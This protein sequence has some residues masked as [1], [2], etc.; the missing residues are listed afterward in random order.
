MTALISVAI[1]LVAFLAVAYVR[2]PLWFSS[3]LVLLGTAFAVLARGASPVWLGVVV[4]VLAVLNLKPL[5]RALITNPLFG[6]FKKITPPMSQTEQ[7]AVDAGTVWWDRDLFSGKP[8]YARLHN[9]P[10]PQLTAEEQAFIDGPT[11][12]LC[13]MLDDWKITHETKDLEQHVWQ[14]IKDQGFLGMIIKKEYGGKEFSNYAHARVVTKIATRSGSA[15]VTVMVPN[16]LGP[17]ELL[18]HYGTEQQKNYYLPRLAKGVEIPCFALTSPEAGSDAGGI[19]DYGVVTRGSYTDPRTGERHE[20]VLGIRV[21]WE[22]RYITLGPIATILGLAFK[23]YDPDGLLGGKKDIGITCALIPTEHEGVE[24]GRRHYPATSVFQN[25]PNWGNNVFIPMEWVIG[26]KDY[27]GQGW[28][29]LVEC[30][31]VGRCISLPA[32]SVASGKLAAFTTGAYA[33]IRNQFGLAI[34]KFEGV[35]EAIARIGG[36]A[37]QMDAAQRLALTGLDIGE[38]P[39]V[40]SGI[41]KYHNTERMRKV[42]ND[43][44]DVHA[45]KAVCIGPNNYLAHGYQA[46]PVA[47]TVEGANILTRSMIIFG[48]G[49][50]RCHPYVLTEMRSAM[51]N[52]GA[53]FDSAVIGHIGF[54]VSN[55]VRALVMGLTGAAFVGS[56]KSGKT[57]VYY[58]QVTRMSSAFAFAA[59]MGMASLGGSL[60]FKEKLSARLGDALSNLYIATAVLKKYHDDGMP[61][62]DLPLLQWSVQTALYDCQMALDGFLS[63]HPSPLLGWLMRRLVFPLGMS[64]RAP[65]DYVGTK[66]AKLLMEP[67]ATRDRL[68]EYMYRSTDESDPIGVLDHALKAVI[69]TEGLEHKLRKAQRDGKNVGL[70]AMDRLDDAVAKGLI[71]KEEHAAVT[72]ARQLKRQVIMVDDFDGNLENPDLGVTTRVIL[73]HSAPAAPVA[74]KPSTPEAVLAEV[75]G[76]PV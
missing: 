10:A 18:Q 67:T 14:F 31:S 8:D 51:N 13:K 1:V 6:V 63:N 46:I 54:T 60:K 23:L 29:M 9:F 11:E 5:R 25:G 24:I 39:S 52:D 43:A 26:G 42:L 16:S 61:E 2:A 35:D 68:V 49:A 19:P 44:M 28:R 48:Q 57:A 27:V 76:A 45:G 7:E 4:V 70:T 74:P 3:L 73:G 47:I 64:L 66:V 69:A 15:A 65:A 75:P 34:G 38:K 40:L 62:E 21:S 17:G 20:N 30:L 41:L 58:K 72:R 59:D 36:Y 37:Y 33:R 55:A 56:P 32:M 22:K 12:Q 53:A 71:S 50:I